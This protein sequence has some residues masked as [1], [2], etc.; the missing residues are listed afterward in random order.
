[1][2]EPVRRAPPPATLAW[3]ARSLAPGAQTT[4]WRRFT[5]GIVT[6]VHR[7]RIVR[8]GGEVH[9]LVLKRW[10]GEDR[11]EARA[12]AEREAMALTHLEGTDLL[13]PRLIAFSGGHETDGFP[14]VLMSRAPGR[15]WL[16]PTDPDDW[17][18]Q[19][20]GTLV[21]IHALDRPGQPV[22]PWRPDRSEPAPQ[23]A[24]RPEVWRRAA[25][26]LDSAPPGLACFVHGDYQHFNVLWSHHRVSA[27]IDWVSCG[28][29]HPDMD[30]GHC[31]LNLAAL[32]SPELAER[33]RAVYEA[34][35]GRRV[36]A[37]WDVHQLFCYTESWPRF[38]PVQVDRRVPVDTAGM[39]ARVETLL[40]MAIPH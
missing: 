12:E 16:D 27:V 22:E 38:L 11:V 34:E 19:L 28:I 33:F 4:G 14:A 40:A 18:A 35:A 5:G 2:I 8:K 9:Y 3:A 20:A 31:R 37:W 13:T 29:G 10:V 17:L 30:V 24:S 21:R 7:L 15:V 32:F 36:D 25:D 26:L 6:S 23:G 39:T 1:M